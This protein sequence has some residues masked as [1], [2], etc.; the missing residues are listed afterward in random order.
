[1]MPQYRSLP[2]FCRSI[3]NH[4]LNAAPRAAVRGRGY[5]GYKVRHFFRVSVMSGCRSSEAS[6]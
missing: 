5:G 3:P 1:M 2:Q 6:S 4:P